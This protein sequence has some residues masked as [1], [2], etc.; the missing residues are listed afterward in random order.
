MQVEFIFEKRQRWGGKWE[1]YGTPGHG[2]APQ[3]PKPE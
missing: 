3:G 1:L 2:N